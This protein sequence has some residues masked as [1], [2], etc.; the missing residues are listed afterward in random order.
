MCVDHSVTTRKHL[1]LGNTGDEVLTTHNGNHCWAAGIL[2]A[3]LKLAQ[4]QIGLDAAA[5]Q[6]TSC[7][8][9]DS[10]KFQEAVDFRM[11]AR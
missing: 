11:Q 6:W 7:P 8:R 3:F 9:R 2:Q 10:G 1:F 4:L 5:V